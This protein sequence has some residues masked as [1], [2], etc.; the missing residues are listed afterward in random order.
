MHQE[1]HVLVVD[2]LQNRAFVLEAATYSIGRDVTNAIVINNASVSRQH[3]LLLRLPVPGTHLYRYRLV[4][5]NAQ[6]KP[7]VNGIFINGQRCSSCELK[8][9]D[10]ITFGLDIQATYLKV[11]MPADAFVEYL[12]A[13]QFHS[14]KSG[15]VSPKETMIA[16]LNG[17]ELEAELEA[18]LMAERTILSVDS[19][20]GA[21]TL[22]S[23]RPSSFVTQKP[24]Q[25]TKLNRL[26]MIL[27]GMVL[28]SVLGGLGIWQFSV[29]SN[30]NPVK[31]LA[32]PQDSS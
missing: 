11:E 13:I 18:I 25:T 22:R 24:P 9:G 30:P 12:E 8:N 3:A 2:A 27:A 28:I 1:R 21:P 15:P 4:D 5:G 19:A 6:G 17:A 32:Q 31:P 16:A 7:S 14:I 23:P 29:N 26:G 10:L 20:H